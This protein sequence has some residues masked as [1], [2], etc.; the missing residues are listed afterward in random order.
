MG[1]GTH[2]PRALRVI[3]RLCILAWLLAFA[4]LFR[5]LP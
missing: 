2:R 1:R 5:V 4:L 3:V